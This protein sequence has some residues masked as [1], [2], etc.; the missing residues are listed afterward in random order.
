M[1]F[2]SAQ[3]WSRSACVKVPALLL[4]FLMNLDDPEAAVARDVTEVAAFTVDRADDDALAGVAFDHSA[5]ARRYLSQRW[6]GKISPF[7]N[8]GFFHSGKLSYLD[9]PEAL[10][11]SAPAFIIHIR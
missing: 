9:H 10:Q 3:N 2:A 8:V 6:R 1:V 11:L 4:C 5:V 7:S